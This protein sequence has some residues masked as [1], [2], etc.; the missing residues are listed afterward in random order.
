MDKRKAVLLCFCAM[1]IGCSACSLTSRLQKERTGTTGEVEFMNGTDSRK[2][3][4]YSG[5]RISDMK[6]KLV[7][8]LEKKYNE[9]FVV[10]ESGLKGVLNN[11]D[12]IVAGS[13]KGS[14]ESFSAYVMEDGTMEDE[15]YAV[16]KRNETGAYVK[17]VVEPFLGE[18]YVSA[19]IHHTFGDEFTS[20]T[21][22][23]DACK[24][25]R[26]SGRG[27]KL[28]GNIYVKSTGI[29][30]SQFKEWAEKARQALEENEIDGTFGV[31]SITTGINGE[32]TADE[33]SE[34]KKNKEN[35][36]WKEII[37]IHK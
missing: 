22:F 7:S 20:E 21:T 18:C 33:L 19:K 17:R 30:E 29:T 4:N 27:L 32:M 12:Y 14:D 11:R 31:Y 5:M 34:L 28:V 26:E 1:T 24:K 25:L 2:D 36:D 8:H 37:S 6:G 15:Y 3:G 10:T 16:L 13:E 9:T 35:Y 23:E